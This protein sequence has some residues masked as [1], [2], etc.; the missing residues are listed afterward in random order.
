MAGEAAEVA[1]LLPATVAVAATQYDNQVLQYSRVQYPAVQYS[2]I[3]YSTNQDRVGL[4]TVT[5]GRGNTSLP[6]PALQL[7]PASYEAS[8]LETFPVGNTVLKIG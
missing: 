2:T 5:I 4:A 8:I 3:Q 7:S 6:A 1:A